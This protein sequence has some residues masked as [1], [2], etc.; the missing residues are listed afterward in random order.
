MTDKQAKRPS[1]KEAEAAVRTLL[2]WAGED[3]SREGLADTPKRVAL[4][5][6]DW[7]GGY[8]KDPVKYLQRTFEEILWV[9]LLT[10]HAHGVR[11]QQT[12]DVS[13]E[14]LRAGH[15][16]PGRCEMTPQCLGADRALEAV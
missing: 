1:R 6:E 9:T 12:V 13:L 2:R 3:P 11:P 8:K 4:A 10:R 7:F 15:A 16:L 14:C 5:Y